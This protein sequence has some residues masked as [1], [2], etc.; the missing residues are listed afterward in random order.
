[1]P[2]VVMRASIPKMTEE[3]ALVFA[4][5]LYAGCPAET[6]VLYM[7]KDAVPE[8][9]AGVAR[10]W[11]RDRLVLLAVEQLNGGQWIQLDDKKRYELSLR[12]VLAEMAFYIWNTNFSEIRDKVDLEKHAQARQTLKAEI[13]GVSD[14]DPMSAFARFATEIM[15][16]AVERQAQA[17]H[18]ADADEAP[19]LTE[20]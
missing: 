5:L 20:H 3:N 1:M 18:L 4:Q 9:A 6:A 16:N 2:R 19:E 12:K 7:W 10:E 17:R 8:L 13:S 14:D 15:R 11:L